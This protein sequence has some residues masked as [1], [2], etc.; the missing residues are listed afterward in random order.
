MIVRGVSQFHHVIPKLGLLGYVGALYHVTV[1]DSKHKQ[2]ALRQ[3]TT[4]L[5]CYLP[6]S[7]V[8]KPSVSHFSMQ[9]GQLLLG[10]EECD[11]INKF[12]TDDPTD[13]LPL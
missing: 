13:S 1:P 2:Y 3:N 11:K 4:L 10:D 7:P 8:T 9:L 6:S 5:V 12:N